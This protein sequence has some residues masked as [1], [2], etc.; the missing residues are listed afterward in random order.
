MRQ[1][2]C[3]PGV[4]ASCRHSATTP[5]PAKA[6][7]PWM[8]RPMTFCRAVSCSRVCSALTIP[9]T[10]GPMNSRWLG[11]GAMLRRTGASVN[12]LCSHH[13]AFCKW[14]WSEN[15]AV[16]CLVICSPKAAGC[17]ARGLH[18]KGV[19]HRQS[20][21]AV[22]GDSLKQ[23]MIGRLFRQQA[24]CSRDAK[25]WLHRADHRTTLSISNPTKRR[26]TTLETWRTTS[27]ANSKL[28]DWPR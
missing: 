21:A 24:C 22:S 4:S 19:T 1:S 18:S 12:P 25:G 11:L 17:I 26:D 9:S 23:M 16:L 15:A 2:T 5:R 3:V 13:V 20:G 28:A 6:A 10:T 14:V 27:F 7:S 8:S